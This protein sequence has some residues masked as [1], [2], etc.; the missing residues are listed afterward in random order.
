[1]ASRVGAFA[2][3]ALWLLLELTLHG[4]AEP[5]VP[6]VFVFGD[7]TVD[8]GNNNYIEKC[9]IDCRADYPHFGVDYPDQA[10]TGRFSNGYN[11]AD[12]LAQLL[13]FA[14]S[15]APFLSLPNASLVPQVSTGINFASGGSGL[16]DDTGNGHCGEVL[17]MTE[18]VGNFTNLARLWKSENQTAADLVSKSLFFIS[19]GS[20]DLFE[21]TDAPPVPNRNGTEF[22]QRL[23]ASYTAYLKDL[24]GAGA[25]KFSVVSP[26]LLGCCPSQRLVAQDRKDVDKYGCFG[27]A[28][29]LSNQLY[30]MIASMLHDLSLELPGM[31]YSLVDS[32][33]MVEWV[34]HSP[35]APSY[36]FT[37]LDTACCG[38]GRFGAGGCNFS[39]PLCQNRA[40]HLFWDDYHPTDAASGV[41]AKMIF[42]DAGIF[43]HPI[44]VQQLVA[45]RP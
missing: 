15:P 34:F 21:Y 32:I 17:S 19:A 13:G 12:Q 37:V 1:M 14:E 28:N 30:P 40:N 20:N 38:D 6:A 7:S 45:S 10:P 23:V 8:V 39:A 29:N 9:K 22:L 18:Q 3:V 35:S 42:G 2:L 24:Y 41:A 33:R 36:N 27:S 31:N 44:N 16:L 25:K 4:A 26:S 5:L 11:L 43:V